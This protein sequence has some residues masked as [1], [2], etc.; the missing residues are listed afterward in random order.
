MAERTRSFR[1]TKPV[2][3]AERT[4]SCRQ[5]EASRFGKTNPGAPRGL[6]GSAGNRCCRPMPLRLYASPSREGVIV[7]QLQVGLLRSWRVT[8]ISTRLF[9]RSP[10]AVR[11]HRQRRDPTNLDAA[12]GAI[13]SPVAPSTMRR[14]ICQQPLQQLRPCPGAQQPCKSIR[15]IE[16]ARDTPAASSAITQE[17]P[18]SANHRRIWKDA[19]G[20][21]SEASP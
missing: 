17:G 3:L 1:R 10:S 13:T 15:A 4:R 20:G 9:W 7:L 2:A 21:G 8:V 11:D 14:S 16:R 5:N 6:A 12:S 18:P 19:P